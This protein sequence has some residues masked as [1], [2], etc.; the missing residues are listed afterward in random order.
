[1]EE[2]PIEVPA[3]HRFADIALISDR[4]PDETTILTFRHLLEKQG[5]GEQIFEIAKAR[6]WMTPRSRRPAPPR[7]KMGSGI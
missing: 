7:T 6:L 5:L 1:M 3:M 2:A 4:I